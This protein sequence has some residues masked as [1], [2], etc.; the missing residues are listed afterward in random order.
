VAQ[1]LQP[2]DYRA[3]PGGTETILVVED[4]EDVRGLTMSLLTGLGYTVIEANGSASALTLARDASREMHLMVSDVV[5][6]GI[7]GGELADLVRSLRPG[8]K[9]LLV[10]GGDNESEAPARVSAPGFAFL[11]KPF[12]PTELAV[13]VRSLL[14]GG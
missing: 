10:S 7:P 2:T 9:V 1:T 14:D 8:I 5:M 3:L 13:A 6:P 11:A 4:R 12:T